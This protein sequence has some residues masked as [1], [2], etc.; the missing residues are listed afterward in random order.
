MLEKFLHPPTPPMPKK[1]ARKLSREILK[2]TGQLCSEN[3]LQSSQCHNSE[4]SG[5]VF[6]GSERDGEEPIQQIGEND[7]DNQ[8]IA[9]LENGVRTLSGLGIPPKMTR[10]S[11]G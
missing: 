7:Q 9:F 3:D 2:Q 10:L 5:L 6:E 8:Q 1:S 4:N 11:G